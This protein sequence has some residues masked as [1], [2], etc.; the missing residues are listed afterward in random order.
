M[1]QSP[2]FDLVLFGYRNDVARARTLG[3]LRGFPASSA[4]PTP[5][6]D[7]VSVP[8]R[9]FAGL[10]LEAAQRLCAQLE[11]LGAQVALIPVVT[12]EEPQRPDAGQHPVPPTPRPT[13]GVTIRPLTLL[14]VLLLGA[15]L[16]LWQQ[17][18]RVQRSAPQRPAAMVEEPAPSVADSA[19][20]PNS[21][22][23]DV[24]AMPLASADDFRE[25]VRQLEEALRYAPDDPTLTRKLQTV[26]LHWGVTDL[27]ADRLDDASARLQEAAELGERAEVL[28]ALGVTYW[29]Q[30]DY[31]AAT[32]SLEHALQLAPKDAN[33]MLALAQV[34]LRQDKRPEAFD[35]LRRVK[36][37]GAG[38]P[39][40]DKQLEQLGREVDAEWGFS[41]LQS[42]HFRVSFGDDQDTR[43]VHLILDVLEYA[44][45]TVGEKLDTYPSERT[46]VVLYTQQDFHAVTRTPHWAGAAFDGRIKIPVRGLTEEQPDLRRIV[47]HEYAHSIVAQLAGVRCPVWLNEGVA[48]WAEEEEDGDHEGWA[49]AQIAGQPLFSLRELTDSFTRLPAG[50]V[51]VAYAQSYLTVRALVDRYG[52]RKIPVLLGGLPHNRSLEE[53]YSSTYPGDLAGFEQ[54]V[55][56]DLAG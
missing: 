50:R 26:L 14:L 25:V 7:D 12:A 21:A 5:P 46:E 10:E 29:R 41:Q 44:Y 34:Y 53:A 28:S 24:R 39:D 49:R 15:S 1:A 55:L 45:D 43:S 18:R 33:A 51:Q 16:S 31:A 42:R 47:R 30:G 40:L 6:E 27:A 17:P 20:E 13:D 19:D 52:A 54:Q 9:V 35:L 56:R 2:V 48:V 36:E 11:Q 37:T 8:Q 4:G 3:F 32:T 23:P 38:G 22:P